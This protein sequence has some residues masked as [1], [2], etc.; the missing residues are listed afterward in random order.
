[1]LAFMP[2]FGPLL[3]PIRAIFRAIAAVVETV[4]EGITKIVSNPLTLVATLAIAG[5]AFVYGVKLGHKL[6]G[7]QA[8]A[9]LRACD[10]RVALIETR[11]NLD[12]TTAID[13]ARQAGDDIAP[14]DV[15]IN[16]ACKR[17]ASCRSRGKL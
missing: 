17:S 14:L 1:M 7:Q 4:F 12:V 10:V 2:G 5:L 8:L 11:H 3:A 15:D 9:A 16:E 13:L 6:D